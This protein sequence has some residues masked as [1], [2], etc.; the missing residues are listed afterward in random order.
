MATIIELPN[1]PKFTIK[2][3]SSRTGIPPVT[4]RAWERRHDVL[5][6]FRATNRYRLYSERDIAI[7]RWLK[8]RVDEGIPIGSAVSELR[9]M[10]SKSV[11]PDAI[12]QAPSAPVKPS[13][14][15]PEQYNK[16]IYQA[17]IQ[18]DEKRAGALLREAHS[19]FHLMSVCTDVLAPIV[20]A[21][22]WAGYR[23]EISF[24]MKHFAINYMR[25]KMLS[26]LQSYPS[27]HNAPRMLIGCAP[28]EVNELHSLIVA[29]LLRSEGY[30]VE[31]LGPDV[32]LEDLADYAS[33]EMP[34]VVILWAGSEFTAREMRGMQRMLKGIR[35]NPA[36]GYFGAGFDQSPR[37]R[38]EIPGNY[39]GGSFESVLNSIKAL[40]HLRPIKSA[41]TIH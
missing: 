32:P 39:L 36:L 20:Q 12:P 17:L 2:A 23:G 7:L 1:E 37:L 19:M 38:A 27:R 16:W 26:L 10:T 13:T 24:T 33:H 34:A 21:I 41:R 8:F 3:V 11:W 14:I 25:D 5:D 4:L 15:A 29:V 31:Y 18:H 40:A 6:P 22:E 28:M 30:Q 35:S 9:S